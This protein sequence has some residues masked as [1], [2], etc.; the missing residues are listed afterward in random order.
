VKQRGR[1][2][3]GK[4]MMT[5]G[6][7]SMAKGHKAVKIQEVEEIWGRKRKPSRKEIEKVL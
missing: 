4:G 3:E 2:E 6:Q 5:N 1:G 7:W